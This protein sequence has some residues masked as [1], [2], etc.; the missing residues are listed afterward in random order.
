MTHPA[1]QHVFLHNH[2]VSC[3]AQPIAPLMR[4]F[5][6][7]YQKCSAI[8]FLNTPYLEHT[9]DEMRTLSVWEVRP[10]AVVGLF[11]ASLIDQQYCFL[12]PSSHEQC[13]ESWH[14][15]SCACCVSRERFG[16]QKSQKLRLSR[17]FGPATY[18]MACTDSSPTTTPNDHG[19]FRRK[20]NRNRGCTG[21]MGK[22]TAKQILFRCST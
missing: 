19:N 13:F 8:L 3:C 18:R 1:L 16:L 22:A 5:A 6:F 15:S 2:H 17:T 4:A 10:F 7:G 12:L 14:Q 11:S 20:S 9:A 21:C